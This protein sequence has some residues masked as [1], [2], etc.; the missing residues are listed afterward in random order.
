MPLHVTYNMYIIGV[1]PTFCN[2]ARLIKDGNFAARRS[3]ADLAKSEAIFNKIEPM[4]ADTG[5]W[6][7]MNTHRRIVQI[8]RQVQWK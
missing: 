7:R 6:M 1:L 3:F 4:L 8:Q 5:K 2:A